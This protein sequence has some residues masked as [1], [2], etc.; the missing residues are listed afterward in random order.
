MKSMGGTKM[1]KFV[2]TALAAGFLAGSV[3]AQDVTW[4]ASS[5]YSPTSNSGPAFDAMKAEIEKISDGTMTIDLNLGGS[6]GFT[7]ADHFDVVGAGVIEVAES[8]VGDLVGFDPLF[9]AAALPYIIDS[10]E[11]VPALMEAAMPVFQA[12]FEDSDQMLL[13]YGVFPAAGIFANAPMTSLS[14]FEGVKIRAYDSFSAQAV[15]DLG[16]HPVQLPWSEVV[17]ALSSGLVDGMVTSTE[18]GRIA[19]SWDLGVTDFTAINYSA[20]ITLLHINRD[21]FEALTDNQKAAVLAGADVFTQ[22]YWESGRAGIARDIYLLEENGITFHYEVDGEVK[23]RMEETRDAA[24][25]AWV[26]ENGEAA[27]SLLNAIQNK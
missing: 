18:G 26:A 9:G 23:E 1:K 27:Q 2:I 20:P 24:S 25:A 5:P 16:A 14:D 3:S 12:I 22:T 7:A 17:T 10:D 13:G 6:L 8:L 21:A 15:S 19:S 4:R 11:D